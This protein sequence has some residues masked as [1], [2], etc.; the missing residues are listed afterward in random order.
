MGLVELYWI[1]G[2]ERYR[3]AFERLWRS[4]A[5]SD[6]HN[7]GGFTSGEKAT[8]NPYDPGAIETCCTIAWIALS[9]EMLKLTADSVVADELEL[10]TLNSVV[11]MHSAS[12]RWATYNTPSDGLRRASAHQI[13]FQARAGSPELNCCSVNSPR[14]FGMIGDWAV[15]R[16]AEGI[17]LNYYGPS[18]L[19]VPLAHGVAVAIAQQTAYPLSGAID[20][21]VAPSKPATFALK[22]RIPRWSRTTNVTL[23]GRRVRGVRPGCYLVLNRRWR[24]G[25][26]LRLDLDMRPH[27]WRGERECRGR[28]SIY[29][30]PLLLA[31]DLR[32]NLRLAAPVNRRARDTDPWKPFDATA[33]K[34]PA[35]DARKMRCAPVKWSDWL[36]PLLLVEVPAAGGRRVRLCDFGSAGEGGTPYVSWLPVRR[37]PP[38]TA[39]IARK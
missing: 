31:F 14:G 25:D 22:L 8:G 30:G 39:R 1:T 24:K 17:L 18:R 33:L 2:E 21:T 34:I 29:R 15:M 20:I 37:A 7:N 19:T 5:R 11:G 32:Y 13:V 36:P 23:N 38:K 3:Q 35:L 6:R 26:R 4:M 27:Y 28:T 12:G 16:D 10:S 9:V